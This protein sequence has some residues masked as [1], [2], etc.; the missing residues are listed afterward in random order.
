MPQ[1]LKGFD[2]AVDGMQILHGFAVVAPKHQLRW[3]QKS[4]NQEKCQT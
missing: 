3:L 4:L 2:G 1:G